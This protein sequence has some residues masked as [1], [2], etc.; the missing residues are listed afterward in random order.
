MRFAVKPCPYCAELIQDQAA[1][2]R[3]CGEWLDPSKR[4]AWSQ[5]AKAAAAAVSS[6]PVPTSAS[7]EPQLLDDDDDP[8]HAGPGSTLPVGSG[9]PELGRR[10]PEPART[11][12]APAWLANAQTTR[13]EPR[14]DPPAPTD[15][16]TLEEVALRME[17]IRQSAAAVR[18]A[19]EP[20]PRAVR[21]TA[22]E[23]ERATL[24][25]EPGVTLAAGSLRGV[26][27]DPRDPSGGRPVRARPP[28]RTVAQAP[29]PV[30]HDDELADFEDE[31]APR[32]RPR[33]HR[34]ELLSSERP[35]VPDIPR[36][37]LLA[38]AHAETERRRQEPAR[39]E[40]SARKAAEAYEPELA[41]AST[42]RKPKAA[43]RPDDSYDDYEAP[44]RRSV[45]AEVDHR[46]VPRPRRKAEALPPDPELP[47]PPT[48]RVRTRK[49][50]ALHEDDYGGEP[51]EAPQPTKK[52]AR[53]PPVHDHEPLPAKKTVGAAA[54][55]YPAARK[56]PAPPP[57]DEDGDEAEDELPPPRAATPAF[58]D[59]F[60]D[61]DDDEERDED[62]GDE[63]FEDF[64]GSAPA[65]R[66]LPWRPILIAAGV[67]VLAGVLLFRNELFPSDPE[68][69]A[70]AEAEAGAE[71][72]EEPA[73]A[74]EVPPPTKAPEPAP[75]PQG[76][77]QPVQP[78]AKADA[79]AG[80]GT[81]VADA[82]Q[83][84]KPAEPVALDPDR[85]AALLEIRK[86]YDAAGGN[87]RKL[88]PVGTK[89]QEILTK[90]PDDPEALTFMAQVYLEQGKIDDSLKTSNH[91][92]AVAPTSAGCW[93]TIGVIQH[94]FK[95]DNASAKSAF[96]KYLELDPDGRYAKVARLALKKLK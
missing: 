62:E 92:T 54:D 67:V 5:E 60:L 12:S 69:D 31:P 63:G 27:V 40:R 35:T 93:L 87:P 72:G 76:E 85:K 45:A 28:A 20:T 70:L 64:G 16:S 8:P 66:P 6:A 39:A 13:V 21:P 74:S 48:E 37:Q 15:R 30:V 71:A 77:G 91:C 33:A 11:W 38:E 32:P 59:G 36:E 14:E 95:R 81:L 46:D 29:A 4:P 83:P 41:A 1:K 86:A 58:D 75:K 96:Q 90:A 3:Y 47:G 7:P 65:P 80:A 25:D 88:A 89:L 51:Y 53:T 17:R 10:E 68:T 84:P 24:E 57:A 94:E 52:A 44:A 55:P 61:E 73:P 78:D 18:D 79:G 23:P 49:I 43:G 2:C 22:V 34:D 82:G 9:L 56:M 26:G 19:A 42:V 50:A